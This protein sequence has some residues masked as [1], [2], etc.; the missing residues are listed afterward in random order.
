MLMDRNFVVEVSTVN[1]Y[2]YIVGFYYLLFVCPLYFAGVFA[3]GIIKAKM[4]F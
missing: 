2:D 4:T 1:I 3:A